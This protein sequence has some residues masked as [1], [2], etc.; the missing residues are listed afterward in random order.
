MLCRDYEILDTKDFSGILKLRDESSGVVRGI[1]PPLKNNKIPRL[2]IV[3]G[4]GFL[5]YKGEAMINQAKKFFKRICFLFDPTI[6]INIPSGVPQIAK[7]E[8]IDS[9][10]HVG[11]CCVVLVEKPKI[12]VI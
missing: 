10:E 6:V 11:A 3:P 5:F 4:E 9:V 12:V 1:N 8:L 7:R 2:A